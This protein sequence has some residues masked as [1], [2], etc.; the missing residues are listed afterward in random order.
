LEKMLPLVGGGGSFGHYISHI[1]GSV[2]TQKYRFQIC[3]G[4][5]AHGN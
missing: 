1:T 2:N 4:T 3:D 5:G